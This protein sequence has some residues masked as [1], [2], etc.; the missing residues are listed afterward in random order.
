MNPRSVLGSIPMQE[1]LPVLHDP[2]AEGNIILLIG[3]KYLSVEVLKNP[4]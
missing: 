4:R 2:E 3:G 1:N